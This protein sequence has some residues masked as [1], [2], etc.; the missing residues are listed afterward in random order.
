MEMLLDLA[1]E[2][3][4]SSRT[5]PFSPQRP[6]RP[7]FDL[8]VEY[9]NVNPYQYLQIQESGS[10]DSQR[11]KGWF[12]TQDLPTGTLL[13]VA[14]PI[15]MVMDWQDDSDEQQQKEEEDEEDEDGM[16]Q[17]DEDKEPW[18]NECLLLQILERLKDEPNLWLDQLSSLFPRDDNDL[19]SL[20][21]WVCDDDQVFLEVEQHLQ[22]LRTSCPELTSQH[23]TE[24]AKRLPLIIRYNILSVETCSELLSYPGPKGHACLSGVAL[25]HLPSFF[26]HSSTPNCSRWA[27][28]DVMAFVTN[29]PVSAGTELC[30]S[31]IE[32]DVL[33]ESPY[34]RNRLLRMNFVDGDPNATPIP[35]EEEGPELPVVDSDV[36]NELM[37]M[38]PFE[39][40]ESI[41]QLM[42]QATGVSIPTDE[43]E[44]ATQQSQEIVEDDSEAMDAAP[45]GS[46]WF[47]CDAHNLRILKALTLDSLGQTEKALQLWE[48]AVS[49]VQ[50]RLPPNDESLVVLCTQAA[51]C[52]QH[53]EKM[54]V[55]AKYAAR[56]L[57]THRIL[58]GGGVER[59]RRRFQNEFELKLRPTS[60]T[61]DAGPSPVDV[62]W[63]MMT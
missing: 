34:R 23:V 25:Y 60:E 1:D 32:H 15:E 19:K 36:Q 62:L 29:Q 28:G 21:T 59:F 52:A 5:T 55:A 14:K 47:Q 54:D 9:A 38:D 49:F 2:L 44:Q 11:G 43:Q 6:D 16:E 50:D 22:A 17:D 41:Q 18:L 46:A 13:M 48:E 7:N 26:N 12:A 33:C 8:P 20:P 63:P 45:T 3:V 42:D 61:S 37:A 39:R 58:F 31:Y 40:L 56:A 27:V 24:I 53:A 57:E 30:I 10:N 4:A 35:E 51:L